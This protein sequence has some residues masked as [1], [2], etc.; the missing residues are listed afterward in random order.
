[1]TVTTSCYPDVPDGD[2]ESKA[3]EQQPATP[4]SPTAVLGRGSAVTGLGDPKTLNEAPEPGFILGRTS[5]TWFLEEQ[6]ET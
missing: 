6:E 3:P 1:M 5:P 4:T 2:R